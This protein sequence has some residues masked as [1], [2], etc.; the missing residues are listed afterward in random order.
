MSLVT[1]DTSK[2]HFIRIQVLTAKNQQPKEFLL[3]RLQFEILFFSVPIVLV[4]G[5]ISTSILIKTQYFDRL[6][7]KTNPS[8][9]HEVLPQSSVLSQDA[10][11]LGS[12]N[13]P[14]QQ[15]HPVGTVVN[16]ANSIGEFEGSAS[17][18]AAL[19][20]KTTGKSEKQNNQKTREVPLSHS[21]NKEMASRSFRVDGLFGVDFSISNISNSKNYTM[22]LAMTNL[23]GTLE[24]G[25][26]WVSVLVNT[27]TG[28]KFW[29]TPMPE[30]RINSFGR[31]EEPKQGLA[32]AFR[33]FRKNSLDLNNVNLKITRFEKVVIGFERDGKSPAIANVRLVTRSQ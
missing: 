23:K 10:Q 4:W 18:I 22:S 27:N 24:T 5:V 3:S 17:E 32:Y 8:M 11:S 15:I 20:K 16:D 29:L 1:I 33:S 9:I 25:R 7:P 12:L 6:N 21:G 31:A 30:V 14:T 26:Y 28:K 2:K 13:E 19:S